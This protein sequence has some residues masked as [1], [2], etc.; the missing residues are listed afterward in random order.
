MLDLTATDTFQSPQR[1]LENVKTDQCL[2]LR[3][4]QVNVNTDQGSIFPLKHLL[5]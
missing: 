4:A 2:A 1:N 5:V 3:K